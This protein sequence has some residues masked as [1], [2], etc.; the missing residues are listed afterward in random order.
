MTYATAQVFNP[1]V[2]RYLDFHVNGRFIAVRFESTDNHN[3]EIESYD[4]E[5]EPA[6]RF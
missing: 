6:G 2:D 5:L 3:W 4:L 1:A